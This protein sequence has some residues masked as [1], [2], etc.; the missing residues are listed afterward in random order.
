[1]W[2]LV[3]WSSLK[4]PSPGKEDQIRACCGVPEEFNSLQYFSMGVEDPAEGKE[5]D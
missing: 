4:K 5:K 2:G 3:S 1:M